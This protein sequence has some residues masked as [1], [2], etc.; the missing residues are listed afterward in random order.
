[1]KAFHRFV[2]GDGDVIGAADFPQVAV[3]AT[4]A[5]VIES[6]GDRMR[7]LDLAVIVVEKI[8]HHA[9]QN[10]RPAVTMTV[11]VAV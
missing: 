2:V 4:D 9:V 6:G 8:A 5:G 3:L 11:V 10:S 7:L 1:M